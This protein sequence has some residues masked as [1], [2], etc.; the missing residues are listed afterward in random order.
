MANE[1]MVH[2]SDSRD[3]I[4]S[5]RLEAITQNSCGRN[6]GSN[7]GDTR[8]TSRFSPHDEMGL[9]MGFCG[10]ATSPAGVAATG[11][12]KV[13]RSLPLGP[14]HH[15]P[16]PHFHYKRL[17]FSHAASFWKIVYFIEASVRGL[18][19]LLQNGMV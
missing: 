11:A 10:S 1:P 9:F 19:R 3:F 8:R 4:A 5:L 16:L 15:V 7:L 6:A 14:V 17:R 12:A 18:V 13:G 2:L